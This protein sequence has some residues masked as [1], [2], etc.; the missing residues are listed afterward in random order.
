MNIT[1]LSPMSGIEHTLDIPITEEE[2]HRIETR[3]ERGE[4]I[5]TIVPHLRSAQR[6]FLITGIT[7]DEWDEMFKPDE[8]DDDDNDADFDIETDDQDDT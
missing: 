5:Q 1:R 7:P 8:D 2:L 3:F 4:H 6:E